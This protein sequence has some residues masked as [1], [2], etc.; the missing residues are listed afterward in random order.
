MLKSFPLLLDGIQL[1]GCMWCFAC[2]AMLGFSFAW[3][4]VPETKG[5]NLDQLP[6][7]NK[8]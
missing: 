5:T 1:Y 6:E 8:V 4:V 3:L 2:V 7:S